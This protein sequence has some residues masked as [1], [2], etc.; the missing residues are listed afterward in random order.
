MKTACETMQALREDEQAESRLDQNIRQFIKRF[1]PEDR[2]E[3][4]DFE[5]QLHSIVRD[6]Y[7]QAQEPFHKLA[8]EAMASR[9]LAPI[10]ITKP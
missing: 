4:L 5:M 1:E 6:I 10:V 2:R 9:P 7:R 3:R 8:A